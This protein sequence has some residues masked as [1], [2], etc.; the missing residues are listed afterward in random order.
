MRAGWRL[1]KETTTPDGLQMD[2]NEAYGPVTARIG[3]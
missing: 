2:V 3:P 1:P